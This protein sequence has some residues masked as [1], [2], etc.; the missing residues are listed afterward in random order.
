MAWQGRGRPSS[1]HGVP[2]GAKLS[3]IEVAQARDLD[4]DWPSV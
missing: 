4:L 2:A 3:E 1:E